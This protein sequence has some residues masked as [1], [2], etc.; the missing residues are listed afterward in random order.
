MTSAA[1]ARNISLSALD[2]FARLPKAVTKLNRPGHCVTK[3]I[4]KRE[5]QRLE[6]R[7]RI[8][9]KAL[10]MFAARG[11]EGSALREIAQAADVNHALIKYHFSNKDKLWREAVA[12]LFERM[13]RELAGPHPEDEGASDE[14]LIANGIRRYV[15]YCARHP[16]HARIMVQESI[17]DSERLVWAV[18]KFI[19]PQHAAAQ[20]RIKNA[21]EAGIYPLIPPTSLAYII[22]ASSQIPFVLAPEIRHIYG[23][24]MLHEANVEAH[25]NAMIELF[26]HHRTSAQEAAS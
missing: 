14:D 16:E 17:R 12:F 9:E 11:F 21:K 7:G 8:L 6:T 2:N 3:P 5:L 25:A 10:E 26:F 15:H 23:V 20:K 19:K 13:E 1:M 22:V 24:D 4:N 18:K